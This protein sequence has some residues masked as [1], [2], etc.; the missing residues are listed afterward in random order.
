MS[1]DVSEAEATARAAGSPVHDCP[2]F[3]SRLGVTFTELL[4]LSSAMVLYWGGLNLTRPSPFART[5]VW[6]IVVA[7]AYARGARGRRRSRPGPTGG[8][9]STV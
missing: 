4:L 7:G 9:Q 5:S 8:G 2:D 3:R 6:Q 1:A